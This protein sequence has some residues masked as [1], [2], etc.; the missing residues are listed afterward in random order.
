MKWM[1]C[2]KNHLF[3]SANIEILE[4]IPEFP[5]F[6]GCPTIRCHQLRLGTSLPRAPGV[7]MTW[8]LNKLPQ[9]IH[10]AELV[11]ARGQKSRRKNLVAKISLQQSSRKNLVLGPGPWAGP[12]PAPHGRAAPTPPRAGGRADGADNWVV[13]TCWRMMHHYNHRLNLREFV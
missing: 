5:G 10:P 9:T 3:F 7:R 6:R 2:C 8:V 11:G 12:P 1:K 13:A 4:F